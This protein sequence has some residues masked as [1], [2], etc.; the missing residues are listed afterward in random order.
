MLTIRAMSDGAGYAERHLEYSDYLDQDNKVKGLWRG[1]GAEKL[2][3]IGQVTPDQF[4]RLRQCEDENGKFLRQR[5]SA[6]RI[7]ADGSKQSNAV[8]FYDLTFSAPK[9]ISIMAM[10]D[11]RLLEAHEKAVTSALNE[12][13]RYAAVEDQRKKQKI[14]RQT[15]NLAIA[16]YTHRASRQLDPQTHTHAVVFNL[17]FDEATDK[18][19][20]LD[21]RGFY[22]RRAYLT[23]VYRNVLAREVMNLGHEIENRWNDRGTDL[24]LEIKQ[25]SRELCRKYSKRSVEKEAAIEKFTKEQG[26]RPSDNE[27][28]VLVRNSREDNLRT[29]TTAEVHQYQQSQLT[30]NE[31]QLLTDLHRRR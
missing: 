18:W 16:T 4:E 9:S 6:D 29:I 27:V 24:S 14:V 15:G 25:V 26:R 28:S 1:Q 31:A 17:S 21:A 30:P 3:L 7:A 12:A 13:E 19:K 20:S 11:P 5:R 23:E 8:N 10:E 22:E 2:N